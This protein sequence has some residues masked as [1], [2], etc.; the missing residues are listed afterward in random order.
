MPVLSSFSKDD[1]SQLGRFTAN[2]VPDSGQPKWAEAMNQG[3]G[4]AFEISQRMTALIGWG[5]TVDFTDSWV[6]EAADTPAL[7]AEVP[8]NCEM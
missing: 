8:R 4:G 6:Y 2:G 5:G 1:T 7:D 3:S